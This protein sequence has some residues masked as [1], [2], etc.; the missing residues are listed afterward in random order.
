LAWFRIAFAKPTV[1]ESAE[2][3]ISSWDLMVF[4]TYWDIMTGID[5]V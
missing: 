1:K 3:S 4:Y 2:T 5:M